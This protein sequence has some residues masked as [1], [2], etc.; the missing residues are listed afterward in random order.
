MAII[1]TSSLPPFAHRGYFC[2]LRG[3]P[4]G[5]TLP[6]IFELLTLVPPEMKSTIITK[7]EFVHLEEK[8]CQSEV[9]RPG[10]T[11]TEPQP[12][13]KSSL[14]A[15]GLSRGSLSWRSSSSPTRNFC[16]YHTDGQDPCHHKRHEA[17]PVHQLQHL[18]PNVDRVQGLLLRG[19]AEVL[20]QS[21][22]LVLEE[23][24]I[25]IFWKTTFSKVSRDIFLRKKYWGDHLLP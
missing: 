25:W 9:T 18:L 20:R 3:K 11:G 1:L 6:Q 19:Q 10:Y 15:H 23:E 2:L 14:S 24:V 5:T 12:A 22:N 13:K 16:H 4:G 8:L 17:P 21:V 7:K